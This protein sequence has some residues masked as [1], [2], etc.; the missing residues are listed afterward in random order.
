ML[1]LFY[2]LVIEQVLQGI[3]SLYQ[4][5]EWLRMARR[6]IGMPASFYT[7]RVAVICPLKGIEPGL[8]QN[9]TA[10][11]EFEYVQYEIF[12]VLASAEDPAY[13]FAERLA[14][15]GKR[16][17]HIVRAGRPHDCGEKVN[18]LRVAVE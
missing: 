14:A 18:N 13:L 12:F 9:L 10:L 2:V 16:P 11:T 6:R 8:E 3:Y 15:A 7:P 4:G 1:T 5:V 17:V